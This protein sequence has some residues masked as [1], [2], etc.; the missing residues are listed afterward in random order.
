MPVRLVAAIGLALMAMGR[1]PG[2]DPTADPQIKASQVTLETPH[3][4]FQATVI[5]RRD[6][7]AR[8]TVVTAAHGLFPLGEGTRIVVRPVAVGVVLRGTVEA[9]EPNPG[10]KPVQSRDLRAA[11]RFRGAIGSDNSVLTLRLELGND[12]ARQ[13]FG[14]LHTVPVTPR[15]V[16][17]RK[18]VSVLTVHVIDRSGVEH[19]VRASNSLNPK[20]LAWGARYRP[21]PGDSGAGVFVVA[22]A[23]ASQAGPRRMLIGNVVA[24][25]ESGG[26]AA[27]FSQAEFP[28]L[29]L[30]A[31]P[32]KAAR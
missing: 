9:A 16:P 1:A 12:H 17:D 2:S 18:A 4:S 13:V 7:P 15:P 24:S 28:A 32:Q 26:I 27:L 30:P 21:R 5:D 19:V 11:V 3:A 31:R 29:T 25:D 20:W 22:E 8:L 23:D 10:Y 6:E 14:A